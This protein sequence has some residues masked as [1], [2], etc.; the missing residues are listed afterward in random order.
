MTLKDFYNNPL[1]F[2]SDIDGLRVWC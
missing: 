2:Y 1:L